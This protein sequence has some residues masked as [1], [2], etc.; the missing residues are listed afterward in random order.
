MRPVCVHNLKE[1][2]V[3]ERLVIENLDQVSVLGGK[4]A[5]QDHVGAADLA[6]GQSIRVETEMEMVDI[7]VREQDRSYVDRC[8]GVPS[9][10]DGS[11]EAID[12]FLSVARAQ[13]VQCPVRRHLDTSAL[14][15]DGLGEAPRTVASDAG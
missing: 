13:P 10:S 11:G 15:T 7:P 4:D 3:S 6:T 2:R 12:R 1:R 5:E 14:A 9:G 8:S